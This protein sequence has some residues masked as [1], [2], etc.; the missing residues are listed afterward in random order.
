[1]PT[2]WRCGSGASS[3]LA[4]TIRENMDGRLTDGKRRVV[5]ETLDVKLRVLGYEPVTGVRGRLRFNL[6]PWG[7]FEA[8]G[9]FGGQRACNGVGRQGLEPCP[10]D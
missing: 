8:A 9:A 2:Q 4:E 6:P 5:I 10:P 1:M 7:E 3:V